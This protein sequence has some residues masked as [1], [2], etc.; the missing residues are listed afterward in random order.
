[1]ICKSASLFWARN[2]KKFIMICFWKDC[3]KKLEL[4]SK[5]FGMINVRQK[6]AWLGK[7]LNEMHLLFRKLTSNL[8]PKFSLKI[9]IIFSKPKKILLIVTQPKIKKSLERQAATP[10]KQQTP[11]TLLKATMIQITRKKVSY[12]SPIPIW[13]FKAG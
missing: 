7:L 8:W 9:R 4:K 2:S 1:M 10:T 3:D 13:V 12:P 5:R 6:K 11:L